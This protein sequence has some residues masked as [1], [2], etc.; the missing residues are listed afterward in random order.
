[1]V[2]KRFNI[3]V[4]VRL[5]ILVCALSA[6]V[7]VFIIKSWLI[8]SGIFAFIVIVLVVELFNFISKTNKDLSKFIDA[9]NYQDYSVN[10]SAY[11]LGNAFEELHESFKSTL[12]LFRNLRLEKE[13][14]YQYL[15]RLVKH[16]DIGIIAINNERKVILYNEAAQVL[17]NI[18][19]LVDWSRYQEKCPQL[20]NSVENESSDA[21]QL[22]KLSPGKELSLRSNRFLVDG[23]AHYVVVFQNIKAE[24]E[25]KEMDA[26]NQLIKILTHEI[27][28]SVTP[29]S[30]LS[31]TLLSLEKLQEQPNE[32]IL[33]GLNTISRRSRILLGFVE[34]YRKLAHIPA[35][36][37][38]KVNANE[39][40]TQVAEVHKSRLIELGID[41]NVKLTNHVDVEIDESLIF[42]VFDNLFSNATYALKTV[43]HP[44]IS[45]SQKAIDKNGRKMLETQFKDNGNGVSE[46]EIGQIFIPFFSTKTKGSGI[47][48]SLSRQIIQMHGGNMQVETQSGQHFTV[49]FTLP[50]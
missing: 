19:N 33:E 16:I 40:F 47:G 2:Y 29:I 43:K 49:I 41:F 34:D 8:T 37:K 23:K 10:F 48:L 38:R 24:I 31:D 22:I 20:Y 46:A 13:A 18:P 4:I 44:Q 30:S 35:P 15:L 21:R 11:K 27:M 17:L 32:D 39:F 50:L 14:H 28:N 1:M 7:Y 42:Q 9:I 6:L 26:W 45:I 36:N 25:D 3:N 5:L 12:E